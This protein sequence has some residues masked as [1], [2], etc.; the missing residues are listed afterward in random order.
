MS[1][2]LNSGTDSG[3]NRRAWQREVTQVKDA[4]PRRQRDSKTNSLLSFSLGGSSDLPYRE[5]YRI[6]NSKMA[7]CDTPAT[8]AVTV[9]VPRRAPALS[10]VTLARP[11]S[12][13]IAVA[14]VLPSKVAVLPVVGL[15]WIVKVTSKLL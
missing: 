2:A 4:H 3:S 10:A 12:F 5:T 11:S 1:V 15:A 8:D 14:L 13:V 7:S 9:K 6:V